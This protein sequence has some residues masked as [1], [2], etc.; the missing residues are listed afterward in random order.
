MAVKPLPALPRFTAVTI[1]ALAACFTRLKVEG[2][3]H[4][5]SEGPVLVV[6][7]HASNADGLLL[8][9]YVVPKTGRQMRWL[10]KEEALRW[11]FFGWAMK[12]NGVFAVRRGAGDL[13]AFRLARSVLDEGNVLTIFPE[14]SRSPDGAMREAKEGA[15]V[16]AVRSGAQIVPIGIAN[17]HRFWP[18]GK[19][20][21]PGHSITITIGEPFTLTLPKGGNRQESLHAASLELMRHVA[22]LLPE[23]Q[24][25]VYSEAAA[26]AAASR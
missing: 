2:V 9:G 6:A 1:R 12:K 21:R 19:F 22:E 5:P 18:R 3:E 20:P 16:L 10:G 11:P 8:M 23:E 4:I 25:G 24:R 17:S 14:G 15:A 7:N 13:E 26:S